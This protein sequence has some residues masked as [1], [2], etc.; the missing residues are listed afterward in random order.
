MHYHVRKDMTLRFMILN[1]WQEIRDQNGKKALGFVWSV[2][3][4]N[5]IVGDWNMY[6]GNEAPLGAKEPMFRHYQN[7]YYRIWL[8]KRWLIFPMFDFVMQKNNVTGKFDFVVSP[9]FS[10][11]Y[12]VWA[13]VGVA[14]RW[15]YLYNKADIV[16][17][18]KTGTANGWQSNSLTATL[19]YLPLPQFT[20]R[21]EGRYGTNKDAVFRNRTNVLVREDYY[22]IVSAAFHF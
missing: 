20:L 9:A 17:E 11:R 19:E 22:G 3:R 5:K 12:A 21:L 2:N 13:K 14:L 15:D 1:G 8:G 6:W 4:P 10:V 16:P 18:L 7:L